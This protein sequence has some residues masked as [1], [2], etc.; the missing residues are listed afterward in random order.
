MGKKKKLSPINSTHVR[1]LKTVQEVTRG[2]GKD[3]Q[4]P[5]STVH[6][7]VSWQ[8]SFPLFHG[9]EQSKSTNTIVHGLNHGTVSQPGL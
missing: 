4:T 7:F 1:K 9:A 3:K 2:G 5:E 8:N 6:L